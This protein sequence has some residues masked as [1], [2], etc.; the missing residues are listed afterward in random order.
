[1]KDRIKYYLG[2]IIKKFWEFLAFF[3]PVQKNMIMFDSL[4]GK[5][6]SCNPR[7]IYEKLL[8]E[9]PDLQFVWVFKNPDAFQF[10]KKNP[11]TVICKY[12]SMKHYLYCIKTNVAVFNWKRT[13]DLPK[14]K[15]QLLLQTWHGGGCYKKTGAVLG[16]QSKFHQ[17]VT[18][19]EM[20]Q[21]S[22]FV[23]S[24]SY[25]TK[26]VIREQYLYTGQILE[27][28]MPRNDKMVHVKDF[29]QEAMHIREK[30]GINPDCFTVLYAPTY[31]DS[32]MN[33][34]YEA[35]DYE[36]LVKSVK[37]RFGKEVLILFRGH[38]LSG[39]LPDSQYMKNVTDYFDMQDLLLISDMLISD[40]SSSIWDYS[41]TYRPCFL[42]TPDLEKYIEGRGL[43]ED[44]YTWGFPVA[45]SNQELAEQILSFDAV[46][47]HQN[48]DMHH[49]NLG[50]FENGTATEQ[51]YFLIL[52]K[53]LG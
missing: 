33:E 2:C 51:I 43:D 39:K 36:M 29:A 34:T 45:L 49:Q 4:I 37:K 1:M 25:F 11:N 10:L 5:Q 7:I 22:C 47:H 42:Y 40:Y 27:S 30:L 52:K 44:I 38:Y 48:M 46:Q 21:V 26:H 12:H 19:S 6:Y 31:R 23:S 17:R 16:F 14:R 13:Y 32:N 9:H 15:G 24:S 41:F 53:M 28:G 50:S 8:E 35:L 18:A 20:N 3:I